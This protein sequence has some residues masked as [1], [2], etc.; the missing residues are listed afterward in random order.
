MI[1]RERYIKEIREFYD[2]DLIK[3]ITG[4]RRSGK[5]VILSEVREEIAKR[6]TNI[7]SLDFEDISVSENISDGIS[8]VKYIEEHRTSG[9]CYVFLDEVQRLDG[10]AE[11]CRTLRLRECSLFISGSNS[12][13]LSGEFTKELSGRYVAFRIRPFVY[14]EIAAYAKELGIEPTVSDYLVWGGFPK[15]FEFAAADA[16]RRYLNDLHETIVINDIVNRYGIRKVELFRRLVN[17]VFVSNARIFSARSVCDYLNSNGSKC[18]ISTVVKYLGYLEE[19]YAIESIRQYSKKAKKEL[20]FYRKVY[21][22]DVAFNSLRVFDNRFDLT[23]NFENI[24]YN[25]LLYMGYTLNVYDNAGR[26][27][28][29]FAQKAGKK[30][31]VQA[32][33]S[34]V[35]EKSYERE[36][37]AFATLD[38]SVQKVIITMDEVDYSTSTVKH[39]TFKKFLFMDDLDS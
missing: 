26:E 27:I 39:I 1:F 38:N 28:D 15:R 19:A 29:F 22:A 30:Y 20:D 9:L 10:W 14:K 8:L 35:N 33:Y 18:S 31:Y 12:K 11:A 7:I 34:V 32:A 3:I 5:S 37:S 21:N 16:Q 24:I 17:F 2:S 4:I 6:V 23:H 25:E 13:L 36:F